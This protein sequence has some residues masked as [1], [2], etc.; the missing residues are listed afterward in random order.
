MIAA[1]VM[2]GPRRRIR[3]IACKPA[4]AGAPRENHAESHL[5]VFVSSTVAKSGIRSMA[6]RRPGFF[7][8]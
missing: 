7:G 6:A 4:G 5:A 1:S 2:L 3:G 8:E